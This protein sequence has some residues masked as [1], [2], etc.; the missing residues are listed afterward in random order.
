MCNPPVGRGC[1]RR[2][3]SSGD[4]GFDHYV[5]SVCRN[6]LKRPD[7]SRLVTHNYDKLKQTQQETEERAEYSLQ[8]SK[9]CKYS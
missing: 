5:S 3:V 4:E 2:C 8:Q 9:Q 7:F 1:D 6:E